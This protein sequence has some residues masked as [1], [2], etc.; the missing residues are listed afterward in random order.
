MPRVTPDSVPYLIWLWVFPSPCTG[1][2]VYWHRQSGRLCI[3]RWVSTFLGVC[4]ISINQS[5]NQLYFRQHGP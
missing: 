1:W 2:Y 4:R 5:I 3:V